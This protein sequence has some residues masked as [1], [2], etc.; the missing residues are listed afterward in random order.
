MNTSIFVIAEHLEGRLAD[1][2]FEML[3]KA[4]AIADADG[5][6]VTAVLA[7]YDVSSLTATLGAADTVILI[8]DE[9]LAEFAPQPYVRVLARLISER[10]P[11]LLLVGSTSMGLDLAPALSTELDAPMISSCV[12]I[13]TEGDDYVLTSQ[14]YGGK[15]M[16]ETAVTGETV[17][18]QILPGVF[19]MEDGQ[20]EGTPEVETVGADMQ[21]EDFRMR[22]ENFIKP[23]A[24][25]LDIT[26][27]PILVS[28]GRG[29][30]TQENIELAQQLADTMGGVVSSSRPIV[31]QDWLPVTRQVGKS[32]MTVKPR[33]Y[34][35][36]G[37]SGAPEHVEGMKNADL[38]VAV[39]T[40]PDA[41]IFSVAHYGAVADIFDVIPALSDHLA[42]KTS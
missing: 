19:R 25:D 37:I 1:M 17:I 40:D 28:V 7:G 29:I 24:G 11:G 39:N 32:G 16:T 13:T 5:G 3:G 23:K 10:K 31:D 6:Q 20:K 33:L 18:A 22:F 38:I 21:P 4:R 35:A 41:P 36:L 42:E 12:D 26:Q 2:V 34:L 27:A 9:L 8:H 14:L 15:I 30:Q